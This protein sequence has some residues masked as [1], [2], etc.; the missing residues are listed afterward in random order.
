[1]NSSTNSGGQSQAPSIDN[2]TAA[3]SSPLPLT[4]D[5]NENTNSERL[6]QQT[7]R[8][9]HHANGVTSPSSTTTN[10]NLSSSNGHETNSANG[11]NHTRNRLTSSST[12]TILTSSSYPSNNGNLN[13]AR[14][15]TNSQKEVLRL[16][17][18]HLQSVGLK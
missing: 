13:S 8:L 6:K 12:Q 10:T 17:G 9:T 11:N 18:Q 15:F 16:I 2:T 5:L 4:P 1:M 3:T 7:Q 14:I